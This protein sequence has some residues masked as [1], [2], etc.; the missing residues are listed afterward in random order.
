MTPDIVWR[1]VILFLVAFMAV[2]VGLILLHVQEIEDN[3]Q[4]AVEQAR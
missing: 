4:P 3:T 1:L 2:C